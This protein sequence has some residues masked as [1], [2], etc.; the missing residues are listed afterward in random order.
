MAAWCARTFTHHGTGTEGEVFLFQCQ[1][2]L[3]LPQCQP[4]VAKAPPK[5]LASGAGAR[6]RALLSYC[7][8]PGFTHGRFVWIDGNWRSGIGPRHSREWLAHA[9]GH[10][11]ERSCGRL[12]SGVEYIIGLVILAAHISVGTRGRGNRPAI[13]NAH[14]GGRFDFSL[15]RM[16]PC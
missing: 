9:G 1:W 4:R 6:A 10:R 15:W 16:E 2:M 7:P 8:S 12:L 3:L 11:R 13:S 14:G 5:K